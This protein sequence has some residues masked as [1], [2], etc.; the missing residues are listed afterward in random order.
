[1]DV[2]PQAAAETVAEGAD[3]AEPRLRLCPPALRVLHVATR[4]H[5]LGL[6]L[7]VRQGIGSGLQVRRRR[8]RP[9]GPRVPA[10]AV[11]AALPARVARAL[12]TLSRIVLPD[13]KEM[14]MSGYETAHLDEIEEVD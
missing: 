10:R 5:R 9:A 7:Q 3:R 12:L 11:R 8:R 4:P 6:P 13:P 2:S 14:S 1:G